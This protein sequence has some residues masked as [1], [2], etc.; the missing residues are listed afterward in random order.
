MVLQAVLGL[1][2]ILGLSL[3]MDYNY[4]FEY[5]NVILLKENYQIM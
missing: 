4:R 2:S 3:Y 5:F 1:L